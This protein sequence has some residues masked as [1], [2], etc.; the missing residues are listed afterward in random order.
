VA[1]DSLRT[2][3][4]C[5]TT[6]EIREF[7]VIKH[8]KSGHP[9]FRTKCLPCYT[10]LNN[11]KHK[12]Y[13]RKF[14]TEFNARRRRE[15]TGLLPDE[16]TCQRCKTVKPI[17]SFDKSDYKNRPRA[18]CQ[19]CLKDTG[20]SVEM[21]RNVQRRWLK[22]QRATVINA[23]GGICACCGEREFKFLTI[24]HVGEWGALHRRSLG[25]NSNTRKVLQDIINMGYPRDKFQVL[26]YN[27]NNTNAFYGGCPHNSFDVMSM[28]GGC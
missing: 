15:I 18:I 4:V 5:A 24:D 12:E 27:C 25:R 22:K 1:L 2:C 17:S 23:L 10:R 11:L 6:L 8:N 13:Q 21:R 3:T 26:C 19:E 9:V 14:S 20:K 16:K 28:A 7:P